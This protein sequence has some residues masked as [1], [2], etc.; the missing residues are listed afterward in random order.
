M[1]APNMS[2]RCPTTKM[3]KKASPNE[4]DAFQAYT[5]RNLDNKISTSSDIETDSKINP[6]FPKSIFLAQFASM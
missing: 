5:I 1:R 2:L 4:V 6:D 3:L